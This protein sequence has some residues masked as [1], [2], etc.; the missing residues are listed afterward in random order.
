MTFIK[1][2]L[3]AA[4]AAILVCGSAF[5]DN[6]ALSAIDRGWY[7]NSGLHS[8]TNMNYV[9]GEFIGQEYRNWFVFDLSNISQ[10]ILLIQFI[11]LNPSGDNSGYVSPD[12]TETYSIFDVSTEINLLTSGNAG[13]EAF[14]DLA[15][16]NVY[17]SQVA[18]QE[19][20]GTYLTIMLNENALADANKAIGGLWAIGGLLTTIDLK[21]ED[22]EQLFSA[23]NNGI[24]NDTFILVI[25][26]N[27]IPG[28][29]D[30]D[31][32]VGTSDLLI[33]L[34]LWGKCINCKDCLA[35][36]DD[37]CN[38]GTSDLLILLNNWG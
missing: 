32:V 10:E 22:I 15:T 9:T 20:N 4:C 25:T 26:A 8:P 28:D 24:L 2:N 27:P 16:G 37:D 11:A 34:T 6:F 1:P 7:N 14:D 23:T 30:G 35:D 13:I 18:S 12:P 31:G 29:L 3:V 21:T 19:D 5:A 17:A 33:L 38:I 36:L